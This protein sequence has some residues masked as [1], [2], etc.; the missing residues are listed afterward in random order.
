MTYKTIFVFTILLL[1]FILLAA[2]FNF[3]LLNFEVPF[4]GTIKDSWSN[5]S[6]FS[7]S[8]LG[9]AVAVSGAYVA[10]VI[11]QRTAEIAERSETREIK[12]LINKSV[13]DDLKSL[14][15]LRSSI[16]NIFGYSLLAANLVED[17]QIFSSIS[18]TLTFKGN[19][20]KKDSSIN[21]LAVLN[22]LN[23][24]EG[25]EFKTQIDD[26]V[27]KIILEASKLNQSL[28]VV[29]SSE[30]IRIFL[31][32]NFTVMM[33]QECINSND[34]YYDCLNT[35]YESVVGVEGNLQ[36]PKL[37]EQCFEEFIRNCNYVFKEQIRS[38]ANLSGEQKNQWILSI[39]VNARNISNYKLEYFNTCH[40]DRN[41]K[42]KL[43]ALDLYQICGSLL[44]TQE[45]SGYLD[46]NFGSIFLSTL[47]LISR[48]IDSDLQ[49]KQDGTLARSLFSDY[50][51]S[52]GL[53]LTKKEINITV[54]NL[55]KVY[56]HSIEKSNGHA[57]ELSQ[58]VVSFAIK[59]WNEELCKTVSSKGM[60][61]LLLQDLRPQV[62]KKEIIKYFQN[63]I[64]M[65]HEIVYPK[66]ADTMTIF[67]EL[68]EPLF[69]LWLYM[70][71]A[72]DRCYYF[73]KLSN[74]PFFL[75]CNNKH[76]Y[77]QYNVQDFIEFSKVLQSRYL[78]TN[79]SLNLEL[80][81]LYCNDHL[82]LHEDKARLEYEELEMIN[83]MI[84]NCS[85]ENECELSN[86]N[87]TNS[88]T[89]YSDHAFKY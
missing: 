46:N 84:F 38:L 53:K 66:E 29:I 67:S 81:I 9:I 12:T 45:L 20:L 80:I 85:L 86:N 50:Q 60:D 63:F 33:E 11:A 30:H 52:Y 49:R 10:I 34:D 2:G 17:S 55:E 35:L 72:M 61:H 59:I 24:S 48:Q 21:T 75:Y 22:Y 79:N 37:E 58:Y 41:L 13:S 71:R 62:Y 87:S 42:H 83:D 64:S 51:K 44:R 25:T 65:H 40:F 14:E 89:F 15:E 26:I 27:N 36:S 7:S 18:N 3:F 54:Q 69:L 32:K 1:L 73:F 39:L 19:K 74:K 47:F 70:N 68:I 31:L 6:D 4:I 28:S 88:N 77:T 16:D 78:F 82:E 5:S 23:S 76:K 43:D 56:K 8:T 57:L